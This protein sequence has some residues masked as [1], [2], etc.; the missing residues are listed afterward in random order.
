MSYL[1]YQYHIHEVP[2]GTERTREQIERVGRH[3]LTD[4]SLFY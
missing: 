1:C 3:W 2:V 4:T